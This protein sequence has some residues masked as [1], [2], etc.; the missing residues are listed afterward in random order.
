M[1]SVRRALRV[2]SF[3]P[4]LPRVTIQGRTLSVTSVRPTI[5]GHIRGWSVP[6]LCSHRPPDGVRRAA[7]SFNREHPRWSS[8]G[9][10]A[11]RAMPHHRAAPSFESHPACRV[12]T[13][14]RCV[15]GCDGRARPW[16]SPG[17][18]HHTEATNMTIDSD[19]TLTLDE[20]LAEIKR[21]TAEVKALT[22]LVT[23]LGIT[24]QTLKTLISRPSR[25]YRLLRPAGE[26]SK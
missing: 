20:L 24:P 18:T 22:A 6:R 14:G 1:K 23:A 26:S 5:A 4:V 21:V 25:A 11:R 12:L 19:N 8:V 7:V 13:W 2:F 15:F 3:G 16:H 17:H 10:L 9:L